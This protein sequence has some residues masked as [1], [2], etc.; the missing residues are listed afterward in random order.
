MGGNFSPGDVVAK[1]AVKRNPLLGPSGVQI[2]PQGTLCTVERAWIATGPWGGSY[3][4]AEME[5][6]AISLVEF[7][8]DGWGFRSD[9]FR[10]AYR[11]DPE[12]SREVAEQPLEPRRVRER[13]EA[14]GAN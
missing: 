11:P 2:I 6:P 3:P 12:V 14:S 5:I 4:L 1:R 13:S 9:S 8:D 10:L 7:E